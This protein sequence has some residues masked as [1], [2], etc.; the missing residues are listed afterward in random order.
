MAD[1]RDCVQAA[2]EAGRITKA[3]ADDLMESAARHEQVLVLQGEPRERA[4]P[5]AEQRALEHQQRKVALARRQA[6]LQA[7]VDSRTTRWA[8]AHP[9]G[10]AA[11]VESILAR[12]ATG[13]AGHTN[14]DYRA[15]AVQ[16]QAHAKFADGL[17]KLRSKAVGFWSDKVLL[18]DTVRSLFGEAVEHPDAAGL[19]KLWTE[20]S[21]WM[22]V[23]FNRAGGDIAKRKDWGLPQT[24]DAGL[25][26]QVDRMEWVG[27]VK[28]R[29]DP[30]RM[31]DEDGLPLTDTELEFMLQEAYESIRTS[32]VIDLVPGNRGSSKLANRHQEHRFLAFKDSKAWLE[33][34]ERFGSADVFHTMT[35]HLE[36]M[37]REIA[38]LEV[39]GPNPQAQFVKLLDLARID[40]ASGVRLQYIQSLYNVSVGIVDPH[41]SVFLADLG[42]AVRNWLA[43]SRLGAAL[44]SSVS[45]VA[46]IR[47]TA[48][49]NGVDGTK[50]A[51]RMV[52]L[53]NPT[54]S[55]DRLLAVKAGLAAEAWSRTALAANRWTDVTGYGFS[56]KAADFTMRASGLTAW[57]DSG[58]KA[59]GIELL[60]HVGDQQGK[61]LDALPEE[62]QR[63]FKSYGIS[64]EEWDIIR[65]TDPFEFSGVKVFSIEHLMARTDLDESTRTAL[66]TKV[67]EFVHSEMRY[68]VPEPDARARAVTTLGLARGTIAGEATR[69]VFQFKSFPIAVVTSH[70]YRG[71]SVGWGTGASYLAQLT[72]STTIMG[73]LAMQLKDISKGR[74]P[75]PMD[76]AKAWAAAFAQGGGGGIYGDF[77]FSDA[78][79]YGGGL[80]VS[81]LGPTAGLVNDAFKL[82][83]GNVQ[84]AVRGEDTNAGGELVRFL[85][86]NTPGSSLWYARLA[87]E[88]EVIDQLELAADPRAR[89]RM[90][91][92]Q[93]ERFKDYGQRYWWRPGQTAPSRGPD[94]ESAV[95][96]P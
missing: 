21:E 74:D 23:R 33:Y 19:A 44:L 32:G 2:L 34:Q 60:G 77:L 62:L 85:A 26:N 30:A 27:F 95:E 69:S 35:S 22:R 7:V 80:L 41:A 28:A 76:N 42:G 89:A 48:R 96:S 13:Q 25:V 83:V 93:R 52:S 56:A 1:L 55:E 61:A 4:R 57:T 45:D 36:R 29:V 92:V 71:A 15:Q 75:R 72:I 90:Q 50:V 79:R 91:R 16:A 70:L 65:A 40:G 17:D 12:D 94:L 8:Q 63:A 5:R 14:V 10:T 78:N 37:S 84:E 24:H 6:G 54:N 82:T 18:R 3:Q 81:A 47:Q 31:F 9:E 49:W 67:Q 43:A 39:L 87:F 59:F 73:A 86:Q 68:A 66:A 58:R 51:R 46:F 88:R 20:T 64:A 11:G 53:L 38:V